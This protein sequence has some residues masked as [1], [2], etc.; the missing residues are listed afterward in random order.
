MKCPYCNSKTKV[1]IL[2]TERGQ[3]RWL[4]PKIGDNGAIIELGNKWEYEG[5]ETLEDT[6]YEIRCVKCGK[7]IK[8]TDTLA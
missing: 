6:R 2:T 4:N 1:E 5:G 8:H 7:T 3:V